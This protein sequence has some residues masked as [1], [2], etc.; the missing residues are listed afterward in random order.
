MCKGKTTE[1]G[2]RAYYKIWS[3][4]EEAHWEACLEKTG[5]EQA[6]LYRDTPREA[7][8]CGGCLEL[9]SDPEC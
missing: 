4:K 5:A 6:E 7:Q 9:N 8:I 2:V 1:F 3:K